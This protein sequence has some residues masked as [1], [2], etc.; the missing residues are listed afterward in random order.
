MAELYIVNMDEVMCKFT[1]EYIAEMISNQRVEYIK[2]YHEWNEKKR[3][4]LAELLIIKYLKEN[5]IKAECIY[6]YNKYGKPYLRDVE[7]LYFSIAHS[8]KWVICAFDDFEIGA[9]VERVDQD[10]LIVIEKVLSEDEKVLFCKMSPYNKV[11]QFC[12][13]WTMKESFVKVM[14]MGLNYGLK[15]INTVELE[16]RKIFTIQGLGSYRFQ[17]F[18]IDHKHFVSLCMSENSIFSI[19]DSVKYFTFDISCKE[20]VECKRT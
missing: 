14:G 9:D 1:N 17:S 18:M 8:G 6:R 4:I 3:R 10:N 20:L 19:G 2:Q 12:R 13:I 5:H 11:M 16:K 15:C 7:Q